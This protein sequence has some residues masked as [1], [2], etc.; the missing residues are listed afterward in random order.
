MWGSVHVL[1]LLVFELLF[2]D[3][4]SFLTSG[5]RDR[6]SRI[7]PNATTTTNQS[8]EASSLNSQLAHRMK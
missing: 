7:K 2:V 6:S 3:A 4:H 8:R 5:D 1:Q